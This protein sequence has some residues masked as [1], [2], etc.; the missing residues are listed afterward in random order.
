MARTNSGRLGREPR[1]RKDVDQRLASHRIHSAAS[2]QR[3]RNLGLIKVSVWIPGSY[4]TY[5]QEIAA[6]I[7]AN[8]VE[9]GPPPPAVMSP[10]PKPEA[11]AATIAGPSGTLKVQNPPRRRARCAADPRQLSLFDATLEGP[12]PKGGP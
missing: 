2:D 12:S 4:R 3:K 5:F 1:V 11:R 6:A 7:R 10:E 9:G 8:P